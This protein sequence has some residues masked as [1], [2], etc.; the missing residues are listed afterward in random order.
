MTNMDRRSSTGT[1]MAIIVT[2]VALRL[3]EE[4]KNKCQNMLSRTTYLIV[5]ERQR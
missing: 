4:S 5:K 2:S 3:E 1:I